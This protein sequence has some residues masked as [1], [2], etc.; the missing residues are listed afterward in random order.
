VSTASILYNQGVRYLHLHACNP[1]TREQTV[2]LEWYSEV[3]KEIRRIHPDLVLSFG[4]SRTGTEVLEA[5]NQRE[6]FSRLK[7]TTLSLENGGAQFITNG[8]DIF[9]AA[10]IGSRA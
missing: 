4:A 10:A 8:M 5:V 7:H 6:E 2:S 3:G 1:A 9:A